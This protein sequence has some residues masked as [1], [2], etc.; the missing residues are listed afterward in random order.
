MV[1]GFKGRNPSPVT[2]LTS[3]FIKF[4]KPVNTYPKI[5]QV[6]FLKTRFKVLYFRLKNRPK[7]PG[8]RLVTVTTRCY[9]KTAS[10]LFTP[11]SCNNTLSNIPTPQIQLI[12]M[13]Y[14]SIII[15]C[16]SITI[17]QTLKHKN[18]CF[19]RLMHQNTTF[20]QTCNSTTINH[21]PKHL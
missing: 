18:F 6:T 5:T 3:V 20:P 21:H 17:F 7:R 16:I 9:N 1:S 15:S 14:S 4:Q 2:A 12:T 10:K 8:D 11:Y 13:Q 19:R